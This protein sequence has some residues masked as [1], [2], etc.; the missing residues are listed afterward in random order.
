MKSSYCVICNTQCSVKCELITGQCALHCIFQT[1]Y[2][3]VHRL[4]LKIK[5]ESWTGEAKL[6]VE[7]KWNIAKNGLG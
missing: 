6:N 4:L 7:I 2:C 1:A 3:A 5:V